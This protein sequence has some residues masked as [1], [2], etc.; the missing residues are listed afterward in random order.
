MVLLYNDKQKQGPPYGY[1]Q[2]GKPSKSSQQLRDNLQKA[3]KLNCKKEKRAIPKDCTELDH[4]VKSRIV[5]NKTIDTQG[6][7]RYRGTDPQ[8]KVHQFIYV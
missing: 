5:C 3:D 8:E 1:V 4:I 6:L 2:N 7:E